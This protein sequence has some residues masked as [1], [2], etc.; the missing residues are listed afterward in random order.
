MPRLLLS[1][2]S[3]FYDIIVEFP[4][5]VLFHSSIDSNSPA[6]DPSLLYYNNIQEN[7]NL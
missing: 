5:D 7:H 2:L 3:Y 4:E 1:A 6:F